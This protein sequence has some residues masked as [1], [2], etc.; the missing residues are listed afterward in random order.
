MLKKDNLLTGILAAL[1]FPALAWVAAYLLKDN[2]YIIGRP[3]MPYIIAIALNLFL[4]RYSYKN[5]GDK[6]GR[7]VIV[8]TFAFLLLLIFIIHPVK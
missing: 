1:V 8:A 6:T 3:S 2:A 4:L 7:G 5:G